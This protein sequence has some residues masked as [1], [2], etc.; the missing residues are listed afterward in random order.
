MAMIEI[1]APNGEIVQ[2][3]AGTALGATIKSVM[4]KNYG[5]PQ[6]PVSLQTFRTQYPQYS[7]E[8]AGI[9]ASDTG[10]RPDAPLTHD[11]P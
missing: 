1:Q 8:A 5:G 3:P 9:G 6:Q 2:F 4:A 7:V 11:A 10:F